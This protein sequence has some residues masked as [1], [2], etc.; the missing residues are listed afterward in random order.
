MIKTIMQFLIFF[1]FSFISGCIAVG[2]TFLIPIFEVEK[3]P[4]ITIILTCI[5]IA[6][7][8]LFS[9]FSLIGGCVEIFNKIVNFIR[10]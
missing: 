4:Y 1:I 6:I 2:Y 9:V 7:W 10:N 3:L 8:F 5:H